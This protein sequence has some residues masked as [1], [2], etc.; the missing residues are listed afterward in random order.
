MSFTTSFVQKISY[1]HFSKNAKTSIFI[2]LLASLSVISCGKIS[3][4]GNIRMKEVK[5]EN[6]NQIE[7]EG[8]FRVFLVSSPRNAVEVETYPNIFD[9]L[10]IKVKD[11]I[12]EISERR[13]TKGVD[14]YNVTVYAKNHPT[15]ISVADSVEFNVSGEIKT[16]NI[17]IQLKNNGKFIGSVRTKK[18]EVD[19]QDTSIAN[20]KGFTQDAVLKVKD[21]AGI[22]APYWKIDNLRMEIRN[23]SYA[24][25]NAEDSINGSVQNTA[26]FTYYNNPVR[27]FRIDKGATVENKELE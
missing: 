3:P 23:G 11:G 8:K 2:L 22:I 24:E 12:L 9:N 25:V 7:T 26:K 16:D 4:K 13:P 20:F 1:M 17:R 10:K 14:F 21:T 19:M 6:F 5:V 27:A 18:T 15:L